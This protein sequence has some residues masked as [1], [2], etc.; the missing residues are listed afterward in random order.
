MDAIT[1]GPLLLLKTATAEQARV[2]VLTRHVR[3]VR[4]TC[5]GTLVV[6]DKYMNL[7]LR[8]VEEEYTVLL[9][10]EREPRPD[11]RLGRGRRRQERRRRT[12]KQ[13]FVRGDSVVCVQRPPAVAAAAAPGAAGGPPGG[14]LQ[15]A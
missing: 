9:R 15:Q 12:L 6:F 1:S 11:G 3:G 2:R 4:G 10:L 7:V 13:V 14:R 8:D 5:T